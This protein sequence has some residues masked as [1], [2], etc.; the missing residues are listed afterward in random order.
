M[1]PLAKS[2]GHNKVYAIDDDSAYI[3]LRV[4]G[5]KP[6][7]VEAHKYVRNA[8]KWPFKLPDELKIIKDE[9]SAYLNNCESSSILEL[10][11]Y[12]NT[13]E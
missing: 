7:F 5:Y 10:L 8:L 6:H 13:D 4:T 3:P 2:L 12:K 1:K 11:G 9:H